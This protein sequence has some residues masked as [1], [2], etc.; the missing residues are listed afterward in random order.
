MTMLK[1]A[2]EIFV[3]AM[4]GEPLSQI[5]VGDY[6]DKQWSKHQDIVLLVPSVENPPY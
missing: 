2:L 5:C 4:S 6:F 1:L 3:G